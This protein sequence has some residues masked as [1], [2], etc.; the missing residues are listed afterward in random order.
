M[1]ITARSLRN[2]RYLKFV[3][4]DSAIVAMT[5]YVSIRVQL[6]Q[7]RVESRMFLAYLPVDSLFVGPSLVTLPNGY[8]QKWQFCALLSA[9]VHFRSLLCT[10][11]QGICIVN[12]SG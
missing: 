5:L 9:L 6:S 10:F 2:T 1:L 12:C 3:H 7:I 8:V 11:V 4:H